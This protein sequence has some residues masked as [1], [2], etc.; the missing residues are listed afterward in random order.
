MYLNK[1]FCVQNLH[2]LNFLSWLLVEAAEVLGDEEI[3]YM[4]DYEHGEWYRRVRD[5]GTP[6]A[7]LAKASQWHCPYHNGRMGFEVILRFPKL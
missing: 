2:L 4:I 1:S 7:N 5:D 6:M 3:T